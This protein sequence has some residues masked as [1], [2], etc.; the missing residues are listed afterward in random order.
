MP[1]RVDIN[2]DLIVETIIYMDERSEY[3][4]DLETGR[5]VEI[6]YTVFDAIEEDYYE[7]LEFEERRVL[8]VAKEI[9][10]GS[11][12]YVRIP[13]LSSS[14]YINVIMDIVEKLDK[15]DRLRELLLEVAS[16]TNVSRKIDYLIRNVPGFYDLWYKH[17]ERYVK[18]RVRNWGK[19]IQIEF[20][21]F[22]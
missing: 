6:P 9:Y 4:L 22:N 13:R 14:D 3:Y 11:S 20:Y 5:I 18:Q 15:E 2:I 17:L 8:D 7:D 16:G 12:R 19:Q 1:R 10:E 21:E